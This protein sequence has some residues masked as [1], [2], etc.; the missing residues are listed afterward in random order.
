MLMLY[1][2]ALFFIGIVQ[3][4]GAIIR[5]LFAERQ[6]STYTIRL[7]QYLLFVIGYFVINYLLIAIDLHEFYLFS[8]WFAIPPF[9]A[10]WYRMHVVQWTR[11]HKRIKEFDKQ[12]MVK[13]NLNILLEVPCQERLKLENIPKQELSIQNWDNN[14][15]VAQEYT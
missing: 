5:I 1:G 9:I 4:S 6:D 8:Y 14:L 11:K 7:K 12:Q 2:I 13:N 3:V 10:M 15:K